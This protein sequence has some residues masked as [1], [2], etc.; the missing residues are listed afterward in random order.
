M[1]DSRQ[2]SRPRNRGHW[3][4]ATVVGLGLSA[5]AHPGVHKSKEL[6]IPADAKVDA[7]LE[8]RE[9]WIDVELSGY[10]RQRLERYSDYEA[11]REDP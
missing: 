9:L 3:L 6:W 7:V 5:C 8:G 10:T 1:D 4:F 2:I 11:Q